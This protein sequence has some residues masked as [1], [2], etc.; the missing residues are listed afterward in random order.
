MKKRM[1]SFLAGMAVMFA[2]GLD[3]ASAQTAGELFASGDVLSA[4]NYENTLLGQRLSQN[5]VLDAATHFQPITAIPSMR[6]PMATAGSSFRGCVIN[7]AGWSSQQ[8]LGLYDITPSSGEFS[9]YFIDD[10]LR[11][12]HADLGSTIIDNHYYFVTGYSIN[13]IVFYIRYAFNLEEMRY[14]NANMAVPEQNPKYL[15]WTNTPYD[16][17]TGKSYGLFFTEDGAGL[18]F[19]SMDYVTMTRKTIGTPQHVFLV[20]A[21]D[22]SDAQLYAIDVEGNLY[23]INK[24]TGT[25]TLVGATGLHPSTYHQAAAI[26]AAVGKLFWTYILDDNSCGVAEVDLKTAETHKMLEFDRTVQFGDL[27]NIGHGVEGSAPGKVENLT[28]NYNEANYENID[29]AFTMPTMTNDGAT[30]LSGQ[31]TY[32]VLY[33]ETVVAQGTAVPGGKVATTI[34]D[35]PQQQVVRLSV[36]ASNNKGKSIEQN[37]DVWAGLD[38]PLAPSDVTLTIDGDLVLLTWSPVAT[39]A[40]DGYV[41][42]GQISYVVRKQPEGIMKGITDE[43]TFSESINITQLDYVT[44]SV[45]AVTEGVGASEP[46][47][48]NRV[49][50]GDYMQCPYVVT[51]GSFFDVDGYWDVI[52]ANS[53]DV[54]WKYASGSKS[55]RCASSNVKADDWLLSPPIYLENGYEYTIRIQALTSSNGMLSLAYGTQEVT[56]PNGLTTIID[57]TALP[58]ATEE[59]TLEGRIAPMESGVYR[60]AVRVTE[61]TLAGVTELTRF[62]VS[63]PS[64]VMPAKAPSDFTVTAGEKGELLAT[65]SFVTP[66][67]TIDENDLGQ[68]SS[69]EIMRDERV[70]ATL[71]NVGVGETVTFVDDKVPA[72]GKYVYSA[73]VNVYGIPGEVA[74]QEVYVGVDMPASPAEVT[75]VDNGNG[76]ATLKW[77]NQQTGANGGYVDATKMENKVYSAS[78]D[79]SSLP[80]P[81]D[82]ATILGQCQLDDMLAWVKN[83]RSYT[84]VIDLEGE[85][86]WVLRAVTTVISHEHIEPHDTVHPADN[87]IPIFD[88]GTIITDSTDVLVNGFALLDDDMVE[89]EKASV[90]FLIKGTPARLPMT[91]HF[92]NQKVGETAFWWTRPLQGAASWQL[93]DKAL[94]GDG[95]AVTF[96]AEDAGDVALL[97]TRKIS[98]NGT[99]HPVMTFDYKG[100]ADCMASLAVLVDRGQ[101]GV[102][103]TLAEIMIDELNEA[104]GYERAYIDLEPYINDKYVIV[105]LVATAE[106]ES[107]QVTID[108]VELHDMLDLDLAVDA[109]VPEVMMTG[110]TADF[111]V[112]VTNYGTQLSNAYTVSLMAEYVEDG[113]KVTTTLLSDHGFSLDPMGG[114]DAYH[115]QLDITP[116]ILGEVKLTAKVSMD[117]DADLS[118]NVMEKV[119]TASSVILPGTNTVM[120]APYGLTATW[121]GD[122]VHL[123]WGVV[124]NTI[125]YLTSYNEVMV[126]NFYGINVYVDGTLFTTLREPVTETVVQGLDDGEHVF[127]ITLL[128]GEEG[129]VMESPLSNKAT[130]VTDIDMLILSPV[131]ELVVYSANGVKVAEGINALARL[132]KGVYIVYDKRD[133]NSKRVVKK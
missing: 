89:S 57:A 17:E 94:D 50:V 65:V 92:A 86:G 24:T 100:G 106:Q 132:P 98:L 37:V 27:Y 81:M 82:A 131:A 125:E 32:S 109:I 39:G 49:K 76:T 6:M 107:D 73:R 124:D 133:G 9:P 41:E 70:I 46:S 45:E 63:A 7:D 56:P 38:I 130:I 78:F 66:L 122:G 52:D 31:L 114:N 111:I 83:D 16:K 127:Y 68:L 84:E 55:M 33:G 43:T 72:E 42:A 13:G 88:E 61:N 4:A 116:F 64:K 77:V 67:K 8:V 22:E 5:A 12:M 10:T 29:L 85:P 75:F 51:F 91:E 40:H 20:M 14:E 21:I 120:P 62:S 15:S 69:V 60:F 1:T 105:Q 47:F 103:D 123:H 44:Y 71:Q 87:Q 96:V 110:S 58:A 93:T 97:G 118:N 26:D 121:G 102:V 101:K 59:T 74:S 112:N 19:C 18:E 113:Q 23:S 11:V 48:S 35:L 25:E 99:Q 53:D 80:Q 3:H 30:K 79:T 108:R 128:Y 2:I 115:A 117:G 119:M 34:G 104:L 129:S 28:W 95:G 90:A 126:F 54:T 36:F